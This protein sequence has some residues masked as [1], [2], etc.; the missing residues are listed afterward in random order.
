NSSCFQKHEEISSIE[1][2]LVVNFEIPPIFEN[3]KYYIEA[4]LKSSV[5]QETAKLVRAFYI[6]EKAAAPALFKILYLEDENVSFGAGEKAEFRCRVMNEGGTKGRYEVNFKYQDLIN[7]TQSE[8]LVPGESKDIV[9]EFL[10]AED[11]EEASYEA[12]YK[13]K[14]ET[15]KVNFKIIGVKVEAE[16]GVKY[17]IFKL[18]VKNLSSAKDVTLFAEARCGDYEKRIDFALDEE[19]DLEFN[20]PGLNEKEKIYYGVYFES[21]KSLYLNS[22]LIDGEKPEMLPIKIIKAGCDK[23][24]Y[25]D[26]EIV[27]L[28]WK[29][30]SGKD[31]SVKLTVDLVRP[32]SYSIN[33]AEEETIVL[34]KGV[35]EINK[36]IF[37]ELKIPGIY[38]V[39]YEFKEIGQGS[40]FFDVGEK[41]VPK[42]NHK[43]V[44]F[45][46][47]EKE[48]IAGDSL[49]FFVEAAD[50]DGDLL[51]YSAE[52]I[53]RGASFDPWIKRFCWKPGEKDTGE[54]YVTF[55]VSDG[56]D[57]ASEK[58]K[59]IVPSFIPIIPEAKGIAEPISGMAPL[60]VHF[61]SQ[62]FNKYRKIV[63]YEWD[64]D[65]KGVYDFSSPKSGEAIFIY[66]G[67]GVFPAIL[68]VTD[69]NGIADTYTVTIDVNKNPAAPGAYLNVSPLKGVAPC[70]I[71]FEGGAFCPQGISRY[72]WD[73]DGDGIFDASSS[74]S[75]EVVKTYTFP[76]KYNAEFKVT[77]VDGLTGSEIV[78]IEIEDPKALNVRSSIA[79]VTGSVPLE[80]NFEAAVNG[81]GLIQKYQ[82]D[83][84]GD[85]IFDYTSLN[86][87]VVKHTYCEPG[88]YA[89]TV[90]VTDSNNLSS[91]VKSEIRFGIV[92]PE[93]IKKGKIILNPKKGNAPL[94]VRFSFETENQISDAEYLWDFD[95]DGVIDLITSA[96]QSEFTYNNSGTYMAKLDV[97]TADGVIVS[98]Y[99]II[100]VTNEKNND[101]KPIASSNNVYRYKIGKIELADK[102]SLVLP[103]DVL[104]Q[105]DVV[106]IK[107]LEQNQIQRGISLNQNKSIGEYREYE[108]ENRKDP[109]KKE[110]IISIPYV[111]K[112]E[113]GVVDDKNIEELTL[114]VYWYDEDTGEWKILADS[115]VF[116]KENIVTVKTS[117]FTIFGIA[118][119]EK[120][121]KDIPL[122]EN[123]DQQNSDSP[124]GGCFIATAAFGSSM[125]REVVVLRKF[126]DRYL[127][128][129]ETG[130]KFVNTYYRFS[131]PIAEFIKHSP[132]L[133]FL[134]RI[135]IKSLVI[136]L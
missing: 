88:V 73:F 131:P 106:N 97:R 26:G 13:F 133:R 132:F 82:W 120:K 19:K 90:C 112:N 117:H 60:E 57:K 80:V 83:F 74:E 65:G 93:V 36:E 105:D 33:I 107:K 12:E 84:E 123:S 125:T 50:I 101:K 69:K 76:G 62:L 46:I 115:L 126:R 67:E 70:K 91:Q 86:L 130:K 22:Y 54:Y 66:T 56:K 128:K 96:P 28:N 79:P 124:G 3:G 55:I 23:D 110:M 104:D 119:A 31:F 30:E 5:S 25:K 1:N 89:P 29:I 134:T 38:R 10:V 109:F 127:L 9:F 99:E 63:K 103:A 4:I 34:K 21:G 14:E 136:F 121:V 48:A 52:S 98:C 114:D 108:F 16:A 118:G 42:E 58:V 8:F 7:E 85:G 75:G 45:T 87:G 35:N 32:D 71:F 49:E 64:F 129:S 44:L 37:V 15:Y 92:D 18:K 100:Y 59:I 6:G 72:E 24:I 78:L 40:I 41:E 68:R 116:P 2:E 43:P 77:S 53:P 11:M 51:I 81:S 102:T 47:G 113:D 135:L 94:T 122:P 39:M 20:I 17:D 95:D 27:T 111:D 61:S